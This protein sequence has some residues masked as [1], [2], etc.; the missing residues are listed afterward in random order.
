MT[1][2]QVTQQKSFKPRGVAVPR[3][4]TLF[5]VGDAVAH[6][7]FSKVTHSVLDALQK[8]TQWD[9]HVLGVNYLGDPHHYKYNV[10]PASIGGDI[11]GVNR[12]PGLLRH[13]KPD[14]IC[15]LNDPWVVQSYIASIK[16]YNK[17]RADNPAKLV[18]YTP[19]DGL[20]IGAGFIGAL[21]EAD[22]VIAYTMF[23][24]QELLKGGLS[25]PSAII[26]HGFD[27]KHFHP[28][29]K[30]QARAKTNIP[31][32]WF[33]VGCTNRNQPRKRIDLSL[34]YFAEWAKDKPANVKFYFHGALHDM[35][36]DIIQLAKYY[37]V[38]QRLIITNPG[39]SAAV[40]V[41]VEFMKYIYGTFDVQVS[42]TEGEGWGL[43]TMEGMACR[44]P[45]IVPEWSAL[46]EWAR[47]GVV[48]VPCTGDAAHTGG[49][50]TIGGIVDKDMFIY[51]L[52]N[53]YTDAVKRE[54]IAAAGYKLVHSKQYTWESVAEQFSDCFKRVL[55]DNSNHK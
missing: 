53:L 10:Y 22:L 12:M 7:G 13:I 11:Y 25:V 9:S 41:P 47:G 51:A 14:L 39:L 52:E 15:I 33:V 4:Y 40:G 21:N 26:P 31:L 35:G 36:W 50:N 44:I 27:S 55:N 42:T 8:S 48:L 24:L 46:G 54:E 20:N 45:Q 37:D 32:D 30:A 34:K 6:T 2:M 18:V 23:G 38:D 43:T 19:I 28:L 16:E 29:P 3:R 49:I 1:S 17:E 5:W